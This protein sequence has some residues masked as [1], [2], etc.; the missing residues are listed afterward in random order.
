MVLATCDNTDPGKEKIVVF[1][2]TSDTPYGFFSK[3]KVTCTLPTASVTTNPS[4]PT[5]TIKA[6]Y[7]T[8]LVWDWFKLVSIM[9]PPL[10]IAI[11][12]AWFFMKHK[13]SLA[14]AGAAGA[15]GAGAA[16]GAAGGG[17]Y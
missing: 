8:K 16:A 6:V 1:T 10:L 15:A 11:L 17:D 9:M 12:M 2:T 7:S 13:K 5:S 4:N 14:A 3:L